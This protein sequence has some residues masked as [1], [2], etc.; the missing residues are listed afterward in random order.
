MEGYAIWLSRMVLEFNFVCNLQRSLIFLFMADKL[1]LI[2][3]IVL[4]NEQVSLV[5]N[6]NFLEFCVLV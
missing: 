2:S 4:E 5:L 6:F 1:H 3:N